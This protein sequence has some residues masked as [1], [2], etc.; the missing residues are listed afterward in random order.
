VKE[1]TRQDIADLRDGIIAGKTA[2]TIKTGKLRGL[3]RVRGGSG[4]AARTLGLAGAILSYAL[5]RG[6]CTANPVRGVEK[7]A[8]RKRQQRLAVEQYRALGADLKEAAERGEPWQAVTAIWLLALSGCRRGEIERLRVAEIDKS[9]RCLRL[10]DTKTGP[11]IR[12]IGS[13]ALALL[14]DGLNR[15][16]VFPAIHNKKGCYAGLPSAWRRIVKA[17]ELAGVTPHVLRHS[18][19]STA[20]DLDLSI[21]TIGALLGQAGRGLLPDISTKL[22]ALSWWQPK[23]FRGR[24][25][26]Q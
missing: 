23:R 21:P 2:A 1:L 8:Y 16:F 14:P 9:G 25:G 26:A 18:F 19:A 24:F 4:T 12:P 10:A 11:S 20:E 6:Y 5:Q 13:A 17:K 7:P 15:E 22:T 3:A